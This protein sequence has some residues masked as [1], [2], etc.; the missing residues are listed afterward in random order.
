M[1][2]CPPPQFLCRSN[3]ISQSV[4]SSSVTT[5]IWNIQNS[6]YEESCRLRSRQ[7][8]VW[9]AFSAEEETESHNQAPR[10]SNPGRASIVSCV[11][12]P[13]P[14]K[15]LTEEYKLAASF[16]LHFKGRAEIA[17]AHSANVEIT[18]E[19]SYKPSVEGGQP[20]IFAF[21]VQV[22]VSTHAPWETQKSRKWLNKQLCTFYCLNRKPIRAIWRK[23]FFFSLDSFLHQISLVKK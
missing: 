8:S 13:K 15:H 3:F 12:T 1:G 5:K 10:W 17:V 7:T 16:N 14:V 2:W 21:Q 19:Y 22:S 18:E 23:I 4:N 6:K 11:Q 9:I 20:I